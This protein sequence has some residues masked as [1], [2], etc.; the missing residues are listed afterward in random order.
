[1]T[2][3]DWVTLGVIVAVGAALWLGR[4]HGKARFAAA[5]AGARAEGHASASAEAAAVASNV[6]SLGGV[7]LNLGDATTSVGGDVARGAIPEG[8]VGAALPS[9]VVP[10]RYG[11]RVVALM[12]AAGDLIWS[13]ATTALGAR[14]DDN[15]DDR[16][17]TDDDLDDARSG[18]SV[19]G[20]GLHRVRTMP[21]VTGRAFDVVGVGDLSYGV[22]HRSDAVE[23]DD[24]AVVAGRG[25]DGSAD[26]RRVR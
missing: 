24:V 17:G 8:T 16:A 5:I 13:E 14:R 9:G 25:S 19:G 4:R 23:S 18:R 6:L 10:I 26:R 21:T 7:H 1:V 3:G 15:D 12:S 11:G 22:Q 2:V 20:R